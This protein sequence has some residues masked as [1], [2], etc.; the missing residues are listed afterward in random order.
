MLVHMG[1]GSSNICAN[2]G[3]ADETYAAD[4]VLWHNGEHKHKHHSL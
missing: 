2:M 3:A 1:K 4:S